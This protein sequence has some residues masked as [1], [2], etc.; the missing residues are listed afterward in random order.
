MVK[1]GARRLAPHSQ[2]YGF[3][4]LQLV[5]QSH[6]VFV[7]ILCQRAEQQEAVLDQAL[8]IRA[9]LASSDVLRRDYLKA[10]REQRRL[11]QAERE[12]KTFIVRMG[13]FSQLRKEFLRDKHHH[14]HFC[15]G[16][17][18]RSAD[19]AAILTRHHGLVGRFGAHLSGD[20]VAGH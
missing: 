1:V 16:G 19:L 11:S 17:R 10:E 7:V 8:E 14:P 2:I 3:S 9:G 6:A 20:S 18:L 4:E 15:R 12:Q 13:M 5:E